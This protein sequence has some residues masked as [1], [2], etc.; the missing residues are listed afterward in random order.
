MSETTL[1]TSAVGRF[2]RYMP[3]TRSGQCELVLADPVG[4]S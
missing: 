2:L 4:V 1:K 3:A